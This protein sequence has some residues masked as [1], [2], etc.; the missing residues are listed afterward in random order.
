MSNKVLIFSLFII[1]PTF[2]FS[3]GSDGS[4]NSDPSTSIKLIRFEKQLMELDSND[5]RTSFSDLHKKYPEFVD[6]YFGNVLT[7]QGYES[8]NEDFYT[9]LQAF[10]SDKRMQDV[11]KMTTEEFGSFNSELKELDQAFTNAKKYFPEAEV[12]NIYTYISEFT[13]QRFIFQDGMKDGIA[14]GLDLFLGK[15]FDYA[16]LE[17]GSNTFSNYL[18]R[19]Y[20]KEHLVKKVVEAWLEDIMGLQ[21]GNRLI[22]QMMYNGKKT[23]FLNQIIEKPDSIILEYTD[24][25]LSWIKNNENQM[26]AFFLE[27]DW[28]YTTDQYVIKRLTYPSP[29]TEALGMPTS[30]PGQTGNYLGWRIVESYMKR[31]PETQSAELLSIDSQLLLEKAKFKPGR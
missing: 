30:A 20:N 9:S 16:R 4:K 13:L 6:I 15:N 29:N 25:Q 28:F 23:Y 19:T 31:H 24:K 1:F 8:K 7:L 11:Y 21:T 2:F 26:W 18:T 27:K 17:Q 3:C 10:I 14:I 12:P 22:D 5:L